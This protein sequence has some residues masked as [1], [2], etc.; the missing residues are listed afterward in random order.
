MPLLENSVGD[1]DGERGLAHAAHPEH[2]RH[3]DGLRRLPVRTGQRVHQSNQFLH[4]PVPAREPGRNSRRQQQRQGRSV[5]GWPG[6]PGDRPTT[7]ADAVE[8]LKNPTISVPA[9]F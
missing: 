3:N 8:F 7:P 5:Q 9:C 2:R 4:V 6:L 1:R